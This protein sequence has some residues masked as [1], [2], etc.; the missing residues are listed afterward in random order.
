MGPSGQAW[1]LYRRQFS[2]IG[3]LQPMPHQ[4]QDRIPSQTKVTQPTGWGSEAGQ[5]LGNSPDPILPG[6]IRKPPPAS[7][8]GSENSA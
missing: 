2:L 6:S 8:R 7:D 1:P 4:T 3:L 5:A